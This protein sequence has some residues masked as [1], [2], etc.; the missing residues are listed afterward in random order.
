MK[1]NLFALLTISALILSAC[2]QV[3]SSATPPLDTAETPIPL[4]G[5]TEPVFEPA[6]PDS[7][8]VSP[9]KPGEATPAANSW[10]PQPGDN[11]LE[12]GGVFINGKTLVVMESYP[13]Q[14]MLSIEGDLP[15]PCNQLRVKVGEPD[16]LGQIAVEAYSVI[17]NSMA[18]IQVLF[19]FMVN[20]P[21]G[22]YVG[23]TY[24]VLLNGEKVGEIGE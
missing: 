15:T 2:A 19:P 16:A 20:I 24:S 9:S 7:T 6:N 5:E 13:P 21:L 23:V 17:D 3:R 12:M 22:S 14:Y 10:D 4:P 11:K 1:F 18:C 8:V